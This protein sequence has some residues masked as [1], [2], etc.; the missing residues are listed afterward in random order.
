M[1]TKECTKCHRH[2]ALDNFT[3]HRRKGRKTVHYPQCRPCVAATQREKRKQ[4]GKVIQSDS[5]R[6]Y[7]RQYRQ[8]HKD[9]MDISK[10]RWARSEK[11]KRYS[12]E[13]YHC[14]VAR[15]AEAVLANRMRARV[16]NALMSQG[17]QKHDKTMEYVGCTPLR[18]KQH[19][20]CQFSEGM[21]WG[22]PGSVWHVDH[23]IPLVS[24]DLSDPQECSKAFH[25]TNLQPLFAVD[26]LKK[27]SKM[28]DGTLARRKVPVQSQP[29]LDP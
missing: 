27:S 8:S 20:E 4:G 3:V 9:K 10:R 23:I 12:R 1:H 29:F 5:T 16:R 26:N 19:I 18:L 15:T 14:K 11:G 24:F 17:L 22:Q 28:P 13:Y 6:A 25:Y 2:V 7:Q 21:Q